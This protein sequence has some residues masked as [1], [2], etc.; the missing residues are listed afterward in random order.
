MPQT[1]APDLGPVNKPT[2]Q[3][4][5]M[6]DGYFGNKRVTSA[7]DVRGV[8]INELRQWMELMVTHVHD[9]TDTTGGC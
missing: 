2:W 5:S 7:D 3:N 4:G 1:S 6:T 9:Y 8:D